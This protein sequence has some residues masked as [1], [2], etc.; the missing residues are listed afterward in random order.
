MM[1]AIPDTRRR[2]RAGV[3]LIVVL[4]TVALLSLVLYS[5]TDRMIVQEGATR[6]YVRR[7]QANEMIHAGV[8]ACLVMLV[9]PEDVR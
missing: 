1:V 5:F 3:A 6:A 8:A 7:A 9:D 2:R 4:V